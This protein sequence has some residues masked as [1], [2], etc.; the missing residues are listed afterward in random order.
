[1]IWG[2]NP[3][4][5]GVSQTVFPLN[6]RKILLK[7]PNS[8]VKYTL[9]QVTSPFSLLKSVFLFQ[10]RRHTAP[11]IDSRPPVRLLGQSSQPASYGAGVAYALAKDI[12]IMGIIIKNWF[13]LIRNWTWEDSH[14]VIIVFNPRQDIRTV[15]LL[16]IPDIEWGIAV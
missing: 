2:L 5:Y 12:N 11:S 6:P 4:I 15:L 8:L 3:I 13:E 14:R 7:S 1:M 9:S 10:N 16:D